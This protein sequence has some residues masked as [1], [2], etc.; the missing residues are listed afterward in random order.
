[1]E[2]NKI[3]IDDDV[4]NQDKRNINSAISH[5]ENS[6][7]SIRSLKNE[8]SQMNSKTTAAIVQKCEQLEREITG[9]ISNL[10]STIN[11]ITR[12]VNWYHETD[13]QLKAIVQK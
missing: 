7:N 4:A 8:A 13:K 11:V 12:T 6:L 10:L 1:M 5:L 9:M 3:L 2:A